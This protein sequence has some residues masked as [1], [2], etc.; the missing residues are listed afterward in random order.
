MRQEKD[1]STGRFEESFRDETFLKTLTKG[2]VL[3]TKEVAEKVGCSY[4]LA[5]KRLKELVE[6]GSIKGK[7]IGN[8][9]AWWI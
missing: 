7:I 1:V 6:K 5:Y 2:S 3:S 8:S 4:N 9:Y